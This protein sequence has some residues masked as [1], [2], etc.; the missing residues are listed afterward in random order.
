MYKSIFYNLFS[1]NFDEF[2]V[3]C[4]HLILILIYPFASVDNDVLHQSSDSEIK[5]IDYGKLST[6]CNKRRKIFWT[7]L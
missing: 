7:K 4:F 1:F 6:E 5:F 3:I 2:S